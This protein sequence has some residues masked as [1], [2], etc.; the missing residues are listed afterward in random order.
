MAR[1]GYKFP[2]SPQMKPIQF[3]R[4]LDKIKDDTESEFINELMLRSMKKAVYQRQNI[5]HFG[6]AFSHYTHFTSPIRRYPDMLVHR[7]LRLLVNGHYPV[8]L[9]KNIRGIIDHV[10]THC[11]ETEKIAETAERQAVKVKQVAFMARHVGDEFSGVISGVTGFGFFV[12][13]DNLGAE[14]LIRISGI[15][16]DYYNFDEK[17]YRLVGRRSGRIFRLG[18]KVRVIILTVD[19]VNNEINLLP[20]LK[21]AKKTKKAKDKKNTHRQ[22]KRRR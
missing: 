5:G 13:L 9:A 20:V 1:L 2:V 3:A 19:K 6:L 10:S 15:D 4:F 12:R 16:D 21:P 22:R 18:D 7:L 11:S 8:N 14:G 17:H